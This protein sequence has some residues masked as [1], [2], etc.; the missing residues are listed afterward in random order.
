MTF[1]NVTKF[2]DIKFSNSNPPLKRAI[3]TD[4]IRQFFPLFQVEGQGVETRGSDFSAENRHFNRG[5][6]RRL[7][8]I[9][10]LEPI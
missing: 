8:E 6:R 1:E 7:F 4:K 9:I 3:G 2:E 10:E 5:G